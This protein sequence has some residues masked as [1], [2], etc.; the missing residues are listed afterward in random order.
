MRDIKTYY[1]GELPGIPAM[2]KQ[3][4]IP[5]AK[6]KTHK[7]L[8]EGSIFTLCLNKRLLSE[9]AG[10]IKEYVSNGGAVVFDR[11]NKG[12]TL[13]G[14]EGK[15]NIVMLTSSHFRGNRERF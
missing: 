14:I 6:L 5:L 11:I 12:L 4:G 10:I 3:E 2:L 15:R 7:P 9:E 8:S 1:I 13:C